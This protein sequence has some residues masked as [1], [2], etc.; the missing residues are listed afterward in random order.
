VSSTAFLQSEKLLSTES[1]IMDLAGRLN[2]VLEVSPGKEVA[3]INELAVVLIFDVDYT[4][5][6]LPTTDL[7]SI[8]NDGFF[9][10]NNSERDDVLCFS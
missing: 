8:D 1:F 9:T 6:I 3:Q 4:P 2:E 5:A 7:L 10:A